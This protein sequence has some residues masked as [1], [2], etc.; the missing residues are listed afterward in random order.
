MQ[1]AEAGRAILFGTAIAASQGR[2]RLNLVN[3]PKRLR[4]AHAPSPDA[5]CGHPDLRLLGDVCAPASCLRLPSTPSRG[6]GQ[7]RAAF[8]TRRRSSEPHVPTRPWLRRRGL[9][10]CF[11]EGLEFL[12]AGE[13]DEVVPDHLVHRPVGLLSRVDQDQHA[14]DHAAVCL[15][16][17]AVGVV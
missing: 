10:P 1:R 9:L 2:S 8:T 14:D 7:P 17:H 6:D 16:L 15:D 12:E 11:D 4:A 13:A 5:R 3:S